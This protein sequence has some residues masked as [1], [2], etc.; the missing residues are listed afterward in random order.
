MAE[1]A[2][3]VAQ[4]GEDGAQGHP[5][6]GLRCIAAAAFAGELVEM[7]A[8][9]PEGLGLVGLELDEEG[10]AEGGAVDADS[11]AANASGPRSRARTARALASASSG[12][13]RSKGRRP[14][15]RGR[16]RRRP[17]S[18]RPGGSRGPC[19]VVTGLTLTGQIRLASS[20]DA[21]YLRCHR[22]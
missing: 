3:K 2:L 15:C 16:G 14:G 5:E 19:P 8:G 6:E 20:A 1:E 10:L 12:L 22:V 17:R 21:R 13:T 4:V 18:S 7:I 11:E 9:Q